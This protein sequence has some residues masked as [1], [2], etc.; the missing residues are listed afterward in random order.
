MKTKSPAL[1]FY[2]NAPPLRIGGTVADNVANITLLS[3]WFEAGCRW[4]NLNAGLGLWPRQKRDAAA[5]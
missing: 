5:S 3:P 4:D 1:R 2:G